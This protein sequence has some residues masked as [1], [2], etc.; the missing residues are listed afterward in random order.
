MLQELHDGE[1][2]ISAPSRPQR[3]GTTGSRGTLVLE[4]D[5]PCETELREHFR[6]LRKFVETPD[7]TFSDFLQRLSAVYPDTCPRLLD[8]GCGDASFLK[9]VQEL[10]F[11]VFG[12]DVDRAAS[13]A[14]DQTE[15]SPNLFFCNYTRRFTL[16]ERHSRGTRTAKF[17]IITCWNILEHVPERQLSDL[18]T[19]LRRHLD[20]R[21]GLFLASI[22]LRPCY[23]AHGECH[24]AARPESW[25]R[26]LFRNCGFFLLD[27]TFD[28]LGPFPTRF[29]T[30]GDAGDLCFIAAT[31]RWN[32]EVASRIDQLSEHRFAAASPGWRELTQRWASLESSVQRL[33]KLESSLSEDLNRLESGLSRL[34]SRSA[35]LD[36][37][38]LPNPFLARAMVVAEYCRQH[39]ITRVALFGAGRHTHAVLQA[40]K[41]LQGPHVEVVIVSD[42]QSREFQGIPIVKAGDP[43][44]DP[45][46]AI[47]PSSHCYE[48]EMRA[49]AKKAYPQLP[50]I[51]FWRR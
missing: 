34:L 22:S 31:S 40:W 9:E 42:P 23:L 39:G 33:Q 14:F 4:T 48:K 45:V 20:V 24:P 38:D 5:F 2:G 25:W 11:Q 7:T 43:L 29:R 19:T 10:S 16:R 1:G 27:G 13:E 18:L 32:N 28:Y 17:Q 37:F 47:I 41:Y 51:P 21:L 6:A 15:A 3:S 8:L 46:E 36:V 44:P 50:W 30:L 49:V 12:L 35:G 26:N